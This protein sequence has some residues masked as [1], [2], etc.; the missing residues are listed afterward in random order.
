M[1]S[2][3]ALA[4]GNSEVAR[5][6]EDAASKPP[7][8]PKVWLLVSTDLDCVWKLDGETQPPLA[9][10]GATKVQVELGK[11]LIDA[12]TTD[13]IDQFRHLIELTKFQQELVPILLKPLRDG[14]VNAEA[15]MR[16]QEEQRA[17]AVRE[18]ARRADARNVEASRFAAAFQ[19]KLAHFH[20]TTGTIR[21]DASNVAGDLG[22]CRISGR[23]KSQNFS[24]YLGDARVQSSVYKFGGFWNVRISLTEGP[25]GITGLVVS[26]HEKSN[27]DEMLTFLQRSVEL[28]SPV[29]MPGGRG[30]RSQ[31]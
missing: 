20:V 6:L 25:D 22:A 29:P 27:A 8:L 12:T 2:F 3:F 11:H 21:T 31:E 23:R 5:I 10:G 14:R 15:Q 9:A 28:C 4:K 26:F 17:E 1:A 30:G 18:S 7:V 13:G 19:G 24:L 16:R